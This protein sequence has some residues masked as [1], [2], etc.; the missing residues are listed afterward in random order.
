MVHA[1]DG[2]EQRSV[3]WRGVRASD[4]KLLSEQERRYPSSL[5]LASTFSSSVDSQLSMASTIESALLKVL[6]PLAIACRA[7]AAN[8]TPPSLYVSLVYF[9]SLRQERGLKD[10]C[11]DFTNRK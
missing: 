6:W 1:E 2:P 10:W 4:D 3:A 5:A 9:L 8:M 11:L 7:L